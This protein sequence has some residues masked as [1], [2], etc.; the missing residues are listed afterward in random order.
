MMSVVRLVTLV[1]AAL[2]ALPA[3]ASAQPP[4]P[5]ER[6]AAQAIADAAKRLV[7]ADREI[8]E[9]HDPADG[10]DAPRCQRELLRIPLPRQGALRAFAIRDEFRKAAEALEPALA[11][12]R[13]EIANAQTRDPALISGRAA[14][15]RTRALGVSEED[16]KVFEGDG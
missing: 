12:F 6:A 11:V 3:A 14:A 8:G 16:A 5:D 7:A 1:V 10:L 15:D 13:T 4:P 9:D 2:A